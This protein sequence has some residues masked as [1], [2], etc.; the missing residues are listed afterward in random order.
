MDRSPL[1]NTQH[2]LNQGKVAWWLCRP[3]GVG[4]TIF[5]DLMGNYNG[6]LTGYTSG[7]GLVN[8]YRPGNA[9]ALRGSTTAGRV[10][11]G[12]SGISP[13]LPTTVTRFTIGGWVRANSWNSNYSNLIFR[14]NNAAG[15]FGILFEPGGR[16]LTQTGGFSVQGNVLSTAVWYWLAYTCEGTALTLYQDGKQ[17]N[18]GTG[19]PDS[20]VLRFQLGSD[21]QYNRFLDGWYD[22]L[23]IYDRALRA[24]EIQA[25][26]QQSLLGHRDT[27]SRRSAPPYAEASAPSGVKVP[28]HL[29]LGRAC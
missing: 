15:Q 26:Y 8:R 5:R 11:I 2:P 19:T 25:L 16:W 12:T 7:Q 10:E 13:R 18:T 27:L 20:S 17:I 14:G 22:D 28:W 29:L 4:G 21:T 3:N 23:F 24:P 9:C 6:T 1:V